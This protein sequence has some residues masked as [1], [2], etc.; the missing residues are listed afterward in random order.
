M[1]ASAPVPLVCPLDTPSAQPDEREWWIANGIGGY[2]GGTVSGILTRRYHGLLIAPL[3]PPLGR[4][5]L[6]V[7]ADAELI[8]GET[9]TPFHSNVWRGGIVEPQ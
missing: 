9:R 8:D 5:L 7:K 6:L 3:H 1:V 2:A 4:S